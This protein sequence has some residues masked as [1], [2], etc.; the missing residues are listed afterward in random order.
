MKAPLVAEKR[1][2]PSPLF[3]YFRKNKVIRLGCA[4]H[5]LRY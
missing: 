1:Q 3:A 4:G 5:S 2:M